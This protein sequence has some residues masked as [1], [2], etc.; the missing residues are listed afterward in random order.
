[1]PVFEQGRERTG[2]VADRGRALAD[3]REQ[4]RLLRAGGRSQGG[5]RR[6]RASS[7]STS[8]RTCSRCRARV[9]SRRDRA[10][11]R[12]EGLAPQRARLHVHEA[13]PAT[14]DDPWYLTA[15]DFRT[16]QTR[17][18]GARGRRASGFNN[19]YAPVTIGPDGTA[20][21]GHPRRASWRSATRRRRRSRARPRR[22]RGWCGCRGGRV[23]AGRDTDWVAPRALRARSAA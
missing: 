2:P 10:E 1:M 5:G 7:A 23:L 16:G 8:R 3:R 20:Y 12:A 22:G 21:V 17:L 4:L 13:A 15:L 11:R 19:N 14:S 18:E 6:R 9:A